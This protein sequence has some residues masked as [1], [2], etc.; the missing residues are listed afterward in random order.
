MCDY[1]T[2]L[3]GPPGPPYEELVPSWNPDFI[4]D[5]PAPPV[6][7]LPPS[8]AEKVPLHFEEKLRKLPF[9]ERECSIC[10]ETIS[11]GFSLTSCYHLFHVSCL[12]DWLIYKNECPICK[13]LV[14]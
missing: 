9:S 14:V 7:P 12:S 10:R 8:S 6:P 11:E 3:L 13:K 2:N 5:F 1:F 4:Y